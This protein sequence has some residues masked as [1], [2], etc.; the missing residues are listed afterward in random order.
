MHHHLPLQKNGKVKATEEDH[1]GRV[2]AGT[3]HQARKR[4]GWCPLR[5]WERVWP[6]WHFD[7]RLL[8]ENEFLLPLSAI[9]GEQ[10]VSVA[11]RNKFRFLMRKWKRI[12]GH[13][14]FS[15]AGWASSLLG[16]DRNLRKISVLYPIL[17]K[18][19]LQGAP[20]LQGA[21][22]LQGSIELG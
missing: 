15:T 5:L 19:S 6:C 11:S 22:V 20:S 1:K 13:L 21:Q 8:Y 9:Q 16:N 14:V 3:S 2:W 17:P 12:L 10:T 4:Q 18:A 7:S